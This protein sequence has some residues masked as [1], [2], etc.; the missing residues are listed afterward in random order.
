MEKSDNPKQ[1]VEL[2]RELVEKVKALPL[3]GKTELDQ[4]LIQ[5]EQVLIHWYGEESH[6]LRFL[7]RIE[8]VPSSFYSTVEESNHIWYNGLN[9]I[10]NLFNVI[11][12]QLGEKTAEPLIEPDAPVDPEADDFSFYP[13]AEA[14]RIARKIKEEE[15]KS[16][17]EHKKNLA[18]V[19]E[20]LHPDL[21]EF[22]ATVDSINDVFAFI[23]RGFVW[24]F[25]GLF[26]NLKLI[27]KDP[28]DYM[29]TIKEKIA[30][31]MEYKSED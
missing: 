12:G 7:R 25:K 5:I 16:D 21:K 8:F 6:Q 14:E 4:L 27:L 17:P 30:K 11:L 10:I 2:I 3:R 22:E 13:T 31:S 9:E 23:A 1:Q 15:K 24:F 19:E 18:K 20:E 28:W 29:K 26:R